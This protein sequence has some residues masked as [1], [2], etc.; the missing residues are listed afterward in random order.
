MY[1]YLKTDFRLV[2]MAGAFEE[3]VADLPFVMTE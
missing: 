3:H 2:W 1:W